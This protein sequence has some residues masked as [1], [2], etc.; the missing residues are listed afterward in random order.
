VS[1][2]RIELAPGIRDMHVDG[3]LAAGVIRAPEMLDEFFARDLAVDRAEHDSISAR[4]APSRS[5]AAIARTT[6]RRSN[7]VPTMRRPR[8]LLADAE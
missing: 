5:A 6:S 2:V 8:H 7:D 1:L 3:S 4:L